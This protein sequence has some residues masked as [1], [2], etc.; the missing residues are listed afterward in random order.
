MKFIFNKAF[1]LLFIFLFFFGS[2]FSVIYFTQ[3][4][5]LL[6]TEFSTRSVLDFELILNIIIL[7]YELLIVPMGLFLL[8]HIP[9]ALYPR[10]TRQ[11][12]LNIDN[13]PRAL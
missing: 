4:I 3:S 6:L 10:S 11:V 1:A 9:L 5:S 7:L 13:L 8:L 12:S 2:F